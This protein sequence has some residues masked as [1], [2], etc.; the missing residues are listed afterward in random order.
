MIYSPV[1]FFSPQLVVSLLL[2][3]AIAALALTLGE[4][5]GPN[6]DA[7]STVKN[8]GV[9]YANPVLFAVSWVNGKFLKSYILSG[10]QHERMAFFLMFWPF[11]FSFVRSCCCYVRRVWDGQKEQWTLP[12]SSSSG[13][14]LSC[15]TS[16]LFR[17]CY[18][19]HSGW[20]DIK[21]VARDFSDEKTGIITLTAVISNASFITPPSFLNT[22]LNPY[23]NTRE[24]SVMSLVSA[25]STFPLG[26]SWL[27]LFSLLWLISLQKTK[28]L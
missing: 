15:V 18:E 4:D 21:L 7:P 25:F 27:H 3:I 28:S 6:K 10:A 23:L 9:Y 22:V 11:S 24:R 5:Y 14:S 26:W 12:L 2:L 20:Y 8:P 19:R 13:F 17:R 1:C 16:Y